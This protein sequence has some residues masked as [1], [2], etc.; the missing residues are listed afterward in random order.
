[1]KEFLQQKGIRE[2]KLD[3]LDEFPLTFYKFL[4]S[5]HYSLHEI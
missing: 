5:N 1:M 3:T 4:K 2:P